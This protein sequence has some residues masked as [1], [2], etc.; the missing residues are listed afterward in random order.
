MLLHDIG[1][2]DLPDNLGTSRKMDLLHIYTS[3]KINL[4]NYIASLFSCLPTF[5]LNSWDRFSL[6]FWRESSKIIYN[7]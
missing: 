5:E 4:T 6:Y 2:L 1:Y 3:Y 7:I